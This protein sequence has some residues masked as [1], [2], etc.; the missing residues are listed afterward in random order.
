MSMKE[1]IKILGLSL[2]FIFPCSL[3]ITTLFNI[4]DIR[5]DQAIFPFLPHREMVMHFDWYDILNGMVLF[6]FCLII[7]LIHDAIKEKKKK[8]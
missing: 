3:M 7:V 8:K 2:A 4:A 5:F 6:F 1:R